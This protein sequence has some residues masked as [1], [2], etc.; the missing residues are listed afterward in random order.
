[1]AS[2]IQ[3]RQRGVLTLPSKIREK[4]RLE[5]GDVLTLVDLDGALILSPKTSVVPKLA[6]K[7]ERLRKDAGLSLKDL[8]TEGHRQRERPKIH[9]SIT[10]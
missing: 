2:V 10:R 1:M 8:I 6:A 4:Y 5:A 7:I 9:K 3:I